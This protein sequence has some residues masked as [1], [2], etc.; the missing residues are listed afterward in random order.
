MSTLKVRVFDRGKAASINRSAWRTLADEAVVP[1]PFY[2]Y[3]CLLPALEHLEKGARVEV[4]TIWQD[5]RLLALIPVKYNK[6]VF[7]VRFLEVWDH[8]HCFLNTPLITPECDW[9]AIC[10]LLKHETRAHFI[11]IREHRGFGDAAESMPFSLVHTY[12]RA[13][14]K[15]GVGFDDIVARWKGRQRRERKRERRKLIEQLGARYR[16]VSDPEECLSR[17]VDFIA[18]E[19]QGWKGSQKTA[20]GCNQEIAAFYRSVFA[21]GVSENRIEVQFIDLDGVQLAASFR[22]LSQ[23]EAFEIKTTFSE[24][25]G[26]LAPGI[27]LEIENL[28]QLSRRKLELVDSCAYVSNRVIYDIWPCETEIYN[29]I[30]FSHSVRGYL[31]WLIAG[32]QRS[33]KYRGRDYSGYVRQL[34]C[35]LRGG[36]V[37]T[38]SPVGNRGPDT[39]L[40]D[41]KSS[42]Q[43]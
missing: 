41:L 38:A 24:K 40:T 14:W 11:V 27:V 30:Y 33:R 42:G 10:E 34:L 18:L 3:W 23:N 19:R 43:A 17:L 25:H 31:S 36:Q 2:E 8:D 1:N 6:T 39:A 9:S 32:M 15:K 16:Q 20:I 12:S 21:A 26:T 7:R 29:A 4:A 35:L 37:M 22:Y 28:D 13:S 5:D